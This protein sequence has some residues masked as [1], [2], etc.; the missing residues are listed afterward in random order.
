M[1]VRVPERSAYQLLDYIESY[2]PSPVTFAELGAR[3]CTETIVFSR[4]LPN[5]QI[6]AFECNPQTLPLCRKVARELSNVKLI[7]KAATDKDGSVD[8]FAIDPKKTQTTW[9]DGNPGASSLLKASGKYPVEKYVQKRV[10]VK[11]TR[12]DSFIAQ[13]GITGIDVLWMDIQGGELMALEGLGGKL[14]DV[15]LIHTEVEFLEIYKGQPLFDK[16]YKFLKTAGFI[17]GGFTAFGEYSA[18][19]VF[20]NQRL[21]L[22]AKSKLRLKLN[23]QKLLSKVKANAPK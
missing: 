9:K 3:D 22:P 21:A 11:A 13:Q 15:K 23:E 12:L 14:S 5:T 10:T 2:A 7:E 18:D 4:Y 20:I 19:A 17:L 6:Y 16:L 1:D 8:F